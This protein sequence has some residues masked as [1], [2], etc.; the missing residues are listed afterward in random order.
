[1]K[2]TVYIETSVISYLAA[3]PRRD[4]VMAG[5]Q[6]QTR[7]WW[8]KRRDDFEL[9]ISELVVQEASRGDATAA[10]ERIAALT[11]ITALQFSEAADALASSLIGALRLPPRAH[12]DALHI[13]IAAVNGV[14]Y[15]LTWNCR[16]LANAVLRPRIEAVC[17]KAGGVEPPVI[18][19]PYELMEPP[20]AAR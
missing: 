4:I 6:Q 19:T 8:S 20:D 9:R 14:Q 5:Q 7:D 16:H 10:A 17:R 12:P 11:G 13:A 15:L 1:M 2:P 18:C 3:R